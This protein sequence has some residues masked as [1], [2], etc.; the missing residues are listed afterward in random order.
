[1]TRFTPEPEPAPVWTPEVQSTYDHFVAAGGTREQWTQANPDC[2]PPSAPTA[3]T[4]K[5]RPAAGFAGFDEAYARLAVNTV[6]RVLAKMQRSRRG[7][8]ATRRPAW[9]V[10]V[11]DEVFREG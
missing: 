11:L 7:R 2:P 6:G 10:V 5:P 9:S 8:P 4:A 3:P 1:M